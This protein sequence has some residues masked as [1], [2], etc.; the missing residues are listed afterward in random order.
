MGGFLWVAFAGGESAEVSGEFHLEMQP[1][2]AHRDILLYTTAEFT[3]KEPHIYPDGNRSRPASNSEEKW[4][5]GMS[6]IKPC[7]TV[8][9]QGL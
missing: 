8:S 4:V 6:L 1:M 5:Q 2:H 3:L 9:W 7:D